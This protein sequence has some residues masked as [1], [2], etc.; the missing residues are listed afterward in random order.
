MEYFT[1][2][3]GLRVAV[4]EIPYLRSVSIG[5]YV[6]A[7]S[8][9]ELPEENGL[10]HFLEHMAFKGTPTRT[11]RQIA[12]EMDTLG[13]RVNAATGKL[14]THFYAQV[15][16]EKLSE[17][18]DLLADI[19]R[20]SLV[21]DEDFQKER[22][23]I[24]E[25]IAMVNDTP[26]DIIFDVLAEAM[27]GGQPLGQSI[28]G[29]SDKIAAYAPENLLK[30]KQKH[31]GPGNSVVSIAGHVTMQQAKELAE[32]VFG[33][34]RGSEGME[35]APHEMNHPRRVLALDKDTEQMHLCLGFESPAL[36]S[37]SK[38][39]TAALSTILGGGMSSR[40]FQRIRE[41]MG[42]AYS[43]FAGST[44]YPFVGEFD[45]YAAINPRNL[46]QVMQAIRQEIEKITTLGITDTEFEQTK[47]QIRTNLL[48]SLESSRTA[49]SR[50]GDTLLLQNKLIPIDHHLAE[51][52]NLSKEEINAIA[53]QI[54]TGDFS[55]ALVGKNAEKYKEML[56]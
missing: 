6:K 23:V 29:T 30:Y 42:M 39:A 52:E 34:W 7:G 27:F 20:N 25:E 13:G 41:E 9:L 24:Q 2:D 12:E 22:T 50:M 44:A 48:L 1:L 56:Q 51:L 54:L 47:A 14:S 8:M 26:D 4:E 38:Y 33:D 15:I 53:R 5:I 16:D 45:I 49:M 31:Y 46:K 19:V 43:V 17:A 40:L 37:K 11:A 55:A 21:K 28:L 3:N 36:G 18:A 35:F 10:S 32:K